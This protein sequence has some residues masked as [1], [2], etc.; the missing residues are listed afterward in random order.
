LFKNLQ[1]NTVLEGN[2]LTL[3]CSMPFCSSSSEELN[4]K[5]LQKKIAYLMAFSKQLC[6]EINFSYENGLVV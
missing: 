4:V 2:Q 6:S 5:I 3:Q 1:K